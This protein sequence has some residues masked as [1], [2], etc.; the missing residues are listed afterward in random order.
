MNPVRSSDDTYTL[1]L[2]CSQHPELFTRDAYHY[3]FTRDASKW[4]LAHTEFR[5]RAKIEGFYCTLRF[6]DDAS[7]MAFKFRWH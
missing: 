4:L 2:Q 3:R 6:P 1:E 5:I 7:A